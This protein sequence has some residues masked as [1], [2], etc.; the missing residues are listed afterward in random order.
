MWQRALSLSKS[1][2]FSKAVSLNNSFPEF[3]FSS[4]GLKRKRSLHDYDS[5]DEGDVKIKE[6][7][8]DDDDDDDDD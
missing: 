4:K 7:A 3:L 8:D 5:E 2:E 6:E 1:L